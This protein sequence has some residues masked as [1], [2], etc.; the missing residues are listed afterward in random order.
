MLCPRNCMATMPETIDLYRVFCNIDC[1]K[2]ANLPESSAA[3][4]AGHV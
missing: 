4:V 2:I 3:E 1:G